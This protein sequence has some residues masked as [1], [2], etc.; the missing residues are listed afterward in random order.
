MI[1]RICN[2]CP[3][4]WCQNPSWCCWYI[5]PLEYKPARRGQIEH[6][7]FL[8][9]TA[10]WAVF[11]FFRCWINFS[12]GVAYFKHSIYLSLRWSST[13]K[14]N[15][16]SHLERSLPLGMNFLISMLEFSILP[17]SQEWYGWQKYIFTFNNFSNV[18]CILNKISLSSVR[19][20]ISG[21]LF[22]ILTKPLWTSSIETSKTN[23]KNTTRNFRHT[24][25]SNMPFP[26]RPET[27]K[28]PSIS[29]T[30]PR[31][32][33]IFGLLSIN[34]RSL[35][36]VTFL[37]F[38]GRIFFFHLIP[39]SFP[40]GLLRYRYTVSLETYGRCFS[41]FLI[42]PEM[43]CGDCP[44]DR[45]PSTNFLKLS[46]SN[47]LLT[48]IASVSPA[49]VGFVLGFFRIV[50]CLQR[51]FSWVRRKSCKLSDPRPEQYFWANN[52]FQAG[53]LSHCV[54]AWK[55]VGTSFFFFIVSN[56]KILTFISY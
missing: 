30:R 49:D 19:V 51:N 54:H 29:P 7:L 32:S 37:D 34:T 18:L 2:P 14:I 26:S 33:M 42:R 47:Y 27:I 55:G 46:W 24:A 21:N 13:A 12:F 40:Y 25:T 45:A 9:F 5:L 53:W 22:L 1:R 36:L 3:E 23:S 31:F 17:F 8:T 52:S 10:S 44:S 6:L 43:A 39:M 15:S 4:G 11:L 28:S 35:S 16:L 56:L 20:F 38:F 50:S 41:Q 48:P